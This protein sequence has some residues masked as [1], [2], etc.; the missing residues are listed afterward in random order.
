MIKV[1][2]FLDRDSDLRQ[3]SS[4]YFAAKQALAE[5]PVP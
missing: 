3:L 1:V 5:E 2:W 4:A